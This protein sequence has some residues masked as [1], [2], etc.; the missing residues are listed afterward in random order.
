MFK[1]A[2][3]AAAAAANELHLIEAVPSNAIAIT[4]LSGTENWVM[5]SGIAD[6]DP[7]KT[8][9][10]QYFNVEGPWT[11]TAGANMD[12]VEFT[13]NLQGVQVFKQDFKCATGDANCPL[14]SGTVG[15]MW[16]GSFYF[17]VPAVAPPFEYDVHVT[18]FTADGTTQLWQLESKFRI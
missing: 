17:D 1:Y 8:N 5:S 9:N 14:P 15:E 18:A 11:S 16:N 12:K 3:L 10:R 13:C 6:P 4:Q 2:L 7:I